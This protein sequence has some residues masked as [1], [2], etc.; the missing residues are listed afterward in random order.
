[1]STR[2]TLIAHA[3]TAATRTAAFPLDEA[4][5]ARGIARARVLAPA[6]GAPERA[7]TSPARRARETA[8]ALGLSAVPD[9]LL[10]DV[11]NGRWAGRTFDEIAVAEP[12][13]LAA[14]TRDPAAAPH[15]GESVMALLVR[16][17]RWMDARRNERGHGLAIT[18]AALVRAAVIHAIGAPPSS[19]WRIDVQ[20]LSRTELR[21]AANHWTLR[22]I[23][24]PPPF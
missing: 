20:P 1:M 10:A 23:E 18:H 15:G 11:D 6:I 17:G 8:D 4:L 3:P 13:A 14:W 19:F 5:A 22:A 16:V 2:L 24:P 9:P 12:D 21:P 7:W